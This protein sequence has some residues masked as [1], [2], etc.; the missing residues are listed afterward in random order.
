MLQYR[1]VKDNTYIEMEVNNIKIMVEYWRY[2]EEFGWENFDTVEFDNIKDAN[3]FYNNITS[4]DKRIW[5]GKD[6]IM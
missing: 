4:T 2:F 5:V 3:D 1:K 6:R